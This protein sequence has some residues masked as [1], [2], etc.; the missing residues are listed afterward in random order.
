MAIKPGCVPA[1]PVEPAI[2]P[3]AEKKL[4]IDQADPLLL[5]GFND[6]HLRRVE[7]AFPETQIIARG[8]QL[9]LRGSTDALNHIERLLTE[10]III[11]NRNGNLTDNDVET[12]LALLGSENGNGTGTAKADVGDVVLFTPSGGMVRAK[13]PNQARLVEAA[14]RSDIVFAIGPAGTGKCVAGDTLVLTDQ[15]LIRIEALAS[16]TIPNEFEDRSHRV[17][18]MNG[19]VLTSHVYNGGLSPTIRVT[20][21]HGFEIEGTPEHPLLTINPN[22]QYVWKRIDELRMGDFVGLRRN[23]QMFGN[24]TTINYHYERNPGDYTSKDVILNELDLDFAYFIGLMIGDGCMHKNGKGTPGG[25]TVMLS[26]SDEAISSHTRSICSRFGLRSPQYGYDH[27]ICSTQ[28]YGLLIHLG[29]RDVPAHKKS[30]PHAILRAPKGQII[31]FLQGLFDAD[32]T[33]DRRYGNVS[34]STSSKQLAHEVQI[35]LLNLGIVSTLKS[36][37]T[38][39]RDSYRVEMYG[40]EAEHFFDE[41]GFRLDR[42]QVLRKKAACHNPNLD[43]V[44]NVNLVLDTAVRTRTFTRAQHKLFYDYR[45]GRRRP[46]YTKLNELIELLAG[47]DEPVQR[48]RHTASDHFLWSEITCFQKS[49]AHV[50]DLT[51]PVEHN[52]LANGF[53]NHNTYTGVA[54]AVAALKSRQV[55][56]IIL[57]RP[58]VEAGERLGFL[59]G[60]FREKVDPYLRPLYDALEE[61]LP[62]DKLRAYL[63]QHV[64]EIVPLAFMRGRT[65]STAFVILDEAQNATAMQMKM[66]LT[67]IGVNSRTIITG[68]ITQIDLPTRS[69]SG[70]LE[71]QQILEGIDGID[72]VYFDQGD[73]VRHRLVKD[74]INAYARHNGDEE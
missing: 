50:Y 20:T 67:R 64:I 11:L 66:F 48:L 26:T 53:I 68:D 58:A 15:G 34:L 42:K 71:A 19:P 57:C 24:Q 21:K 1:L 9:T 63:E 33:V 38:T 10:L 31:A 40:A 22:G 28:L 56:R 46:S 36:R 2:K 47:D 59:P 17:M 65:L 45:I 14:R 8:N 51:V 69:Q 52:F 29:V 4:T 7:A 61:M 12:A 32:G 37:K 49:Q 30:I 27:R 60:D 70:L 72:F 39:H 54:L 62:G 3:L 18:S 25:A 43:V 55:K 74:I 16:D 6:I 35:V 41:I 23:T 73:V 5:F 13:T 44:P